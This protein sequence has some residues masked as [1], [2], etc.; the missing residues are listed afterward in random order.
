MPTTAPVAIDGSVAGR[1]TRRKISF[2]SAPME[3]AARRKRRS[4]CSAPPTVLITTVKKAPRKVTKVMESSVVGQK[5]IAAG[6][7]ASGGMGRR[8]SNGGKKMALAVRFTAMRRP[9]GMPMTIAAMKPHITRT[10]LR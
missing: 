5:M 6:T 4:I 3:R 7:Q 10:K 2:L 8:I 9:K 1:R